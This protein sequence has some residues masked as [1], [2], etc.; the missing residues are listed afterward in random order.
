[1]VDEGFGSDGLDRGL[2]VVNFIARVIGNA[3][4]T[5]ADEHVC[6]VGFEP[7]GSVNGF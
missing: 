4:L 7:V 3:I 6:G 2:D 1:M 5:A